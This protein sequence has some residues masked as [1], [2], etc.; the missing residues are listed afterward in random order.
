MTNKY[1]YFTIKQLF[2][3]GVHL[4]AQLSKNN[5][6]M[7]RYLLPLKTNN[8]FAILNLKYSTLY[9]RL[10]FNVLQNIISKRGTILVINESEA[11]VPFLK[12]S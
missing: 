1:I 5:S 3:Q 8:Y 12:D 10:S 11:L 7:R 4:G 9:F 2:I 6:N